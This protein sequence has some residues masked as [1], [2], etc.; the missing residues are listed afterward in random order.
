[1]PTAGIYQFRDLQKK[2]TNVLRTRRRVQPFWGGEIVPTATDLQPGVRELVQAEVREFGEAQL[3]ALESDDVPLVEITATETTYRVCMPVAGYS[4]TWAEE[5]AQN[6]ARGNGV[7]YNARDVK[8]QAVVRAIEEKAAKV[9]AV[10]S[11][12]LGFTGFLNNPGVTPINS[13]FDP[14]NAA[15][16]PDQI[17][18]WLLSFVGDVLIN[19]NNVEYPDTM[20][21]SIPL[22]ELLARKRMTDGTTSILKYFVDNQQ[23]RSASRT[24]QRLGAIM[25]L[26]ECSAAYLEANGVESGGTNKDRIVLYPNDPEVVEKHIMSGAIAMLPE[27]W[28]ISKGARRIYPAYTFMSEVMINFPGAFSYIKHAKEA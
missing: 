16:T 18:D 3:N 20:L 19:S 28:T 2:L 12:Q 6:V 27:D 23:A 4:V 22:W 17:A 14:F 26:V 10:G 1:M 8:M 13:S 15:S 25:P 24:G 7:Q 21:V 9:T 11:T 5:M